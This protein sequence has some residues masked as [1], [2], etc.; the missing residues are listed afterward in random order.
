MTDDKAPDYNKIAGEMIK[1]IVN[2][3]EQPA[4]RFFETLDRLK[5]STELERI[6]VQMF[7]TLVHTYQNADDGVL[8]SIKELIDDD[9][10][11]ND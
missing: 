2:P 3:Q 5:L 10:I 6:Q 9:L 7:R 1:K 11:G 8:K 4:G